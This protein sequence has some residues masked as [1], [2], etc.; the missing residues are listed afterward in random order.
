MYSNTAAADVKRRKEEGEKGRERII[1][2]E[3]GEDKLSEME[4]EREKVPAEK[5]SN[6]RGK[7]LKKDKRSRNRVK[8]FVGAHF[9]SKPRSS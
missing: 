9:A 2:K 8:L 1:G 5:D 3:K 4:V 7:E 6:S